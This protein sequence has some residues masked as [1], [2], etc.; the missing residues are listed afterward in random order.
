MTLLQYVAD[1]YSLD[2][3][4]TRFTTSSKT[5]PSQIASE[6]SS[7]KETR[8]DHDGFRGQ[9]N[10]APPPKWRT[11][12]F[13]YHGLIFLVMVPWMFYTVYDVSQRMSLFD[14][15]S[16]LLHPKLHWLI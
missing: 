11:P 13:L 2:T 8:I 14:I 10:G 9:F 16:A 15:L 6:R 4:D 3:L 7:A 1:L 12:E 5:P